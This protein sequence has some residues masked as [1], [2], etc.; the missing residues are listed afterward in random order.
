MSGLTIGLMGMDLTSL[1]LIRK[2]GTPLERK[3]S[4]KI[5]PVVEKHHL[6]SIMGQLVLLLTSRS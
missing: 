6:V 3:Y 2:A 5:I 1:H 4:A